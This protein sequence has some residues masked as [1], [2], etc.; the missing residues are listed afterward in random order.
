[1]A[2]SFFEQPILNNPYEAPSL[3]HALDEYGQPRDLP[4]V[5]GRRRSEIITPVPTPRMQNP[6]QQQGV[7]GLG[8]RGDAGQGEQEYNPTPI[9][10]EIRSHVASWRALPNP[11]DWSVTPTSARLLT[12]WRSRQFSQNIGHEG[13]MT[14]R[15]Y[16]EVPWER[17]AAIIRALGT[18]GSEVANLTIAYEIMDV[19]SR[20][21]NG[22]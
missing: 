18:G 16:G 10:N 21:K 11:A 20:R 15:S 2:A 12:Y 22:E 14:F 8:D 9:I 7:L 1:M 6:R 13:V 19:I 3:H 17:Q 5:A 4:P